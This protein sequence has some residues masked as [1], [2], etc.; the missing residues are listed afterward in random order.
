[1]NEE[2]RKRIVR[3]VPRLLAYFK[4]EYELNPT[5]EQMERAL[6]A[7]FDRSVEEFVEDLDQTLFDPRA[8]AHRA[9]RDALPRGTVFNGYR[10]FSLEKFS[11]VLLFFI[12][13]AGV[14]MMTRTKLN[15]LAFYSDFYHHKATGRSITGTTYRHLPYG[16]VVDGYEDILSYLDEHDVIAIDSVPTRHG[17]REVI[18]GVGQTPIELTES[19]RETLESVAA[20]FGSMS[21]EEISE[22]SH[23]ERAW[24]DTRT[25]EEIAYGYSMFLKELN[26]R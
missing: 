5:A 24:K 1:M 26:D 20:R 2:I 11:A 8:K 19:E 21:A 9:L 16:P 18:R 10:D 17:I 12:M 7:M 6:V 23:L 25:G 3:H 4:K 13:R 22:M 15:K 14:K